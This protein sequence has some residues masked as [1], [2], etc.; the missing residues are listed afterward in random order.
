MTVHIFSPCNYHA[1]QQMSSSQILNPNHV[2]MN[3]AE[4]I[5][6]QTLKYCRPVR[7]KEQTQMNKQISLERQLLDNLKQMKTK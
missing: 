1:C 3:Q 7:L 5:F 4:A 6:N 2:W